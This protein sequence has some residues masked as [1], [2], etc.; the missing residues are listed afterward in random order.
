[1]ERVNSP[2]R[3]DDRYRIT[4]LACLAAALIGLLVVVRF[5]PEFPNS[6][7]TNQVFDTEGLPIELE[8][9][10]QTEQVA[11]PP[12]PPAP[13]P[14]V[15]VPDD[16]ILDFEQLDT[17]SEIDIEDEGKDNAEAVAQGPRIVAK[18]DQGP[19]P[20]RFVEP[21]YTEAARKQNVKASVLVEVLIDETGRV[22]ESKIVDRFLYEKKGEP[23][24]PV[25]K[26]GYGVEE[27]ALAAA[28]RWRFRPARH[29][30]RLVQTYYTLTFRFGV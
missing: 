13:I 30:G 21:E 18:A 1:M 25:S 28:E 17:N 4:T 2:H 6:V 27:A 11:K 22:I 7:N 15:V 20:I 14:P 26:V 24:V 19:K 9:I 5:W 3:D 10:E 23:P 16:E 8:M 12:P 29:G